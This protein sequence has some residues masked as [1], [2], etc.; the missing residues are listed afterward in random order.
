VTSSPQS[1]QQLSDWMNAQIQKLHAHTTLAWEVQ[2]MSE[3]LP[4]Q[5]LLIKLLKMTTS[6]NDGEALTALRK[7]NM[8]LLSAGWDWEKLI[9][10]KIKVIEDPFK[11]TLDPFE[12][13]QPARRPPP[14]PPPPRPTPAQRPA[15]P[16][17]PPPPP[18]KPRPAV[19]ASTKANIY[20][21]WCFCCGQPVLAQDGFIFDPQK[22]N[23][24]ANSKWQIVCKPCNVSNHPTV[25]A[26]AF[27]RQRP[28]GNAT[29]S[30]GDI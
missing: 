20:A 30:L 14:P 10:G 2:Q 7:A 6:S 8:L 19:I 23:S 9:H 12:N 22:H 29:P 5:D 11:N 25:G 18:P 28:L 15:P 17:P 16:P 27:P 1:W 26:T 24:R 13:R 3:D 4:K 21:G